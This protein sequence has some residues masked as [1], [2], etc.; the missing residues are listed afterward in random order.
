MASNRKYH[1]AKD[2]QMATFWRQTN[3]YKWHPSADKQPANGIHPQLIYSLLI[4]NSAMTK[5]ED[6]VE[7]YLLRS[8]KVEHGKTR[9]RGAIAVPVPINFSRYDRQVGGRIGHLLGPGAL[10]FAL[11]H[12]SGMERAARD[13]GPPRACQS[14][15]VAA[16]RPWGTRY[17]TY[18][19][20]LSSK[21]I[22][23]YPIYPVI[24]PYYLSY[25]ILTILLLNPSY[26]LHAYVA[27]KWHG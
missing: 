3:Y 27:D 22:P 17:H 15:C 11:A 9:Q 18:P 4:H 26:P 8:S 10:A 5:Q 13:A 21:L 16:A 14:R 1:N 12:N 20:Y 24:Y 19:P 7:S 6:T 23:F 2:M 25:F